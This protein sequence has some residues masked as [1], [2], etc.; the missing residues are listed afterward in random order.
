MLA[1][2]LL[3]LL[4]LLVSTPEARDADQSFRSAL[5]AAI[6]RFAS[7]GELDH[8]RAI[9]EK[10]PELINARQTFRE[11]HKPLRTDG[12]GPLHHAAERGRGQIVAYLLE[13]HADANIADGLGWSPLHLAARQG[14]L[15]VVKLLVKHGA[16]VD[17][18]TVA[19]PE[20]FGIP[21]SSPPGTKSQRF[22]AVPARSALQLAEQNNHGDVVQF[23]KMADK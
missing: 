20:T 3:S 18:K 23:L 10:Y 16:K 14:H 4:A 11:P 12:F 22:P 21:P 8:L 6:H 19:I 9:V 5:V 17:A 13:K 1:G 7:E 2:I 15:P